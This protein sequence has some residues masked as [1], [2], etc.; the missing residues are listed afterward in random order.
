MTSLHLNRWIWERPGWPVFTW[1]SASLALPLAAARLAQT[2]VAGAGKLLNTEM[3]LSA[4]LEVLT[5]E[6]IA[7]SAIEGTRFDA[8]ALRT[9]LARRLGLPTAG[10]PTPARSVEGLADVLLDAT[11]HFDEA[12]TLEKLFAWQSALFPTG[13]SGIHEVHVGDLR[14]DDPMRIVSGPIERQRIHYIAP[15]RDRLDQEMRDF[16]SWYNDPPPML[17][18]LLRAGLAHVW[19][20][21]IHP[22]EDGNGRVGR[23]LLDRALAQD[24]RRAVRLYSVSAQLMAT[25][26]EYYAALERASRGS[27]DLT[28]WLDWFLKQFAAAVRES[29]RLLGR[30]THKARFWIRHSQD[31]L[32]QR[33][34][35]ALNLMLDAGPGGFVGG[36]TN[37]KYSHLTKTSTA[38]AQRDLAELVALKCLLPV[39]VGRAARYELP[40]SI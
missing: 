35:K 5:R 11:E 7:T 24:E 28:D 34:R 25:R 39:G 15:P 6:G 9:S 40:P 26:D 10:L 18:G 13:R 31:P 2:E 12:L 17:D 36:M 4:Q 27:L 8:N 29:E 20:E 14:R 21:L 33:Q 37:R 22:F 1:D 3:E 23:A 16:L 38:T 32:N 30:V 19:F